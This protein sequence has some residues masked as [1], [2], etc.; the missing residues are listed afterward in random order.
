MPFPERFA[1]ESFPIQLE[2]AFDAGAVERLRD[3]VSRGYQVVAREYHNSVNLQLMI[4][5]RREEAALEILTE[6]CRSEARAVADRLFP[7]GFCFLL[8]NCAARSHQPGDD[9]SRLLFHFDANFMGEDAPI[10]N[11]WVPFVEVGTGA[12]SLSFVDPAIDVQGVVAH[13]RALFARHQKA[14]PA[15][16]PASIVYRRSELE[17]FLGRGPDDLLLTPV[18]PAG[19]V[20]AFHQLVLHA[21]EQVGA[22]ERFRQS[23][24][25]RICDPAA[26]PRIYRDRDFRIAVPRA[27]GDGWSFDVRSPS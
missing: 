8:S 15:V 20:L 11:F 21:T 6:F 18:L 13:W 7:G 1:A 5:N 16:N 2:R 3:A 17:R 25:F 24:E 26:V 19:S 10:V 12:P 22:G 9:E 23:L 27:D 14:P 4:A